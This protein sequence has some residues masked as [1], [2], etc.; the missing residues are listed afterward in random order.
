MVMALLQNKASASIAAVIAVSCATWLL[1]PYDPKLPDT[2][3]SANALM[4]FAYGLSVIIDPLI[5]DIADEEEFSFA[6]SRL[7]FFFA[8]LV[9]LIFDA[10]SFTTVWHGPAIGVVVADWTIVAVATADSTEAEPKTVIM[11]VLDNPLLFSLKVATK[12]EVSSESP[13]IVSQLPPD[14]TPP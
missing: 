1:T 11:P 4:V 9:A 13:S 2:L 7:A 8:W 14:V 3:L 12:E 5:L 6:N 10:S